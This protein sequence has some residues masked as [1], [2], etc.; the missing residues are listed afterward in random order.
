MSKIMR[1][2]THKYFF[3]I[4]LMM[5]SC[6]D[7]L[8]QS[9]TNSKN[10]VVTKSYTAKMEAVA[11]NYNETDS[12]KV[13][14]G[15]MYMDGMGRPVQDIAIQASPTGKDIVGIHQYDNMSREATQ[16]LPFTYTTGTNNN[17]AFV[18]NA[19][20]TTP[21]GSFQIATG[22]LSNFYNSGVSGVVIDNKPFSTSTFEA[23]PTSRTTLSDIVGQNFNAKVVTPN[24]RFNTATGDKIY[25]IT[26]TGSPLSNST[27]GI[28]DL[29][30][31]TV[32]V[33]YPDNR[34]YVSTIQDADG[35]IGTQFTDMEGKLICKRINM[36]N[37]DKPIDT[38]YVYDDL[39]QL[40][41][42]VTPA[43]IASI[44][45]ATTFPKTFTVLFGA[46]TKIYYFFDYDELGRV[47]VKETPKAG[48][49][50][51]YIVYDQWDRIRCTQDGNQ[52]VNKKWSFISYDK[53]NRPL[54]SGESVFDPAGATTNI[55]RYNSLV[56]KINALTIR[57][58][59]DRSTEIVSQSNSSF[60]ELPT[61]T[62]TLPTEFTLP[63]AGQTGTVNEIMITKLLSV[64]QFDSY[65][66]FSKPG[67]N[68]TNNPNEYPELTGKYDGNVK[69]KLVGSFKKVLSTTSWIRSV[70]FFDFDG[71]AI[72]AS[73]D[74]FGIPNSP[75]GSVT[76]GN[77]FTNTLGAY[78]VSKTDFSW[79]GKAL[80]T[81]TEHRGVTSAGI[82]KTSK[83]FT[84]DHENRLLKTTF[85]ASEDLTLDNGKVITLANL[86][87]NELGQLKRQT[88]GDNPNAP[89]GKQKFAQQFAY[90]YYVNGAVKEM[91]GQQFTE[92]TFYEKRKTDAVGVNT[93]L[94]S[95]LVSESFWQSG[96][97]PEQGQ[98]YNY[99]L[100]NR[101]TSTAGVNFPYSE[102]GITYDNNG[103]IQTLNR[104]WNSAV[105]D[106]LTYNYS[107]STTGA[108]VFLQSINDLAPTLTRPQGVKTRTDIPGQTFEYDYD[109]NGNLTKDGKKG[110]TTA[111][112]Y[113]ILDMVEQISVNGKTV[114]YQYASD[115]EKLVTDMGTEKTVY[116]GAFEYDGS[117]IVVRVGTGAGQLL[118]EVVN[119]TAVYNYQF[120]L[121]DRLGNTRVVVNET[122]D[123]L[124]RS[125]YLAYGMQIQYGN[126]TKNKYLY[127]GK[128]LQTEMGWLDFGARMYDPTIG[129][130]HAPDPVAQ[131]ASPYSYVGGDP[132]NM[133]D[134]DGRDAWDLLRSIIGNGLNAANFIQ[135]FSGGTPFVSPRDFR[136][137]GGGNGGGNGGGGG[138]SAALAG[139][140][141]AFSVASSA[142][143]WFGNSQSYQAA[144][145]EGL[146]NERTQSPMGAGGI[147][148]QR[149]AE[150]FVDVIAS[151]A[152]KNFIKL[153]TF[154]NGESSE[155]KIS[156]LK[157]VLIKRKSIRVIDTNQDDAKAFNLSV[158]YGEVL[159]VD[160]SN[161]SE[162]LNYESFIV[163]TIMNNFVNGTGP[164]NYYFSENSKMSSLFKASD[165]VGKAISQY[166]SGE[167]SG[168]SKKFDF[169][170]EIIY[171]YFRNGTLF[172]I[173]GLVGSASISIR[174][175]NDGI[176]IQIFNVTSLTS[177][178]LPKDLLFL[179]R[180]NVPRS[181][182][183]M[184]SGTNNYS[185]ISQTF[186]LF[187]S[188]K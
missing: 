36:G 62:N 60:F 144:G 77:P 76:L 96:G 175:A 10:Y 43:A 88:I 110:I 75:I 34:L 174:K 140:N 83:T 168:R 79:D 113:N 118:R 97:K 126:S 20:G 71:N 179:P 1:L 148:M 147:E 51:E 52:R 8:A 32:N 188:N 98:K 9:P 152:N 95:G 33:P 125:D 130:W 146:K 6:L 169:K 13:D 137:F 82:K 117:G 135:S 3:F 80:R 99:D 167:W 50:I 150:S 67:L 48:D 132:I 129:R 184:K 145:G 178:Y 157:G 115:G 28:Q 64:N 56:V 177:G 108:K 37:I 78:E 139:L 142:K 74:L 35:R 5:I 53:L 93:G 24:V 160:E 162:F 183:R 161:S 156:E 38:Y 18:N 109:A 40:R 90:S 180:R 70:S 7:L 81:T 29:T 172:S 72:F 55:A 127:E 164:E 176:K 158:N 187:I 17:G 68:Y 19:G 69:G 26:Y 84:Y 149:R 94:F 141:T 107:A 106:S 2:F 171:D 116:A 31:F 49:A 136:G 111:M 134:P 123:T 128:E 131:F 121:Q 186:N 15:I 114:K 54:I 21:S 100:A 119:T 65:Q 63:I 133:I 170:K 159:V 73:S 11:P 47:I 58:E 41:C 92:R 87:Y 165:I 59:T 42:I 173:T 25:Q 14:I 138:S 23:S 85:R 22:E 122:G 166:K 124:Q 91:L 155:L 102:R 86:E 104:V 154:S 61:L 105:I 120:Y 66:N 153:N 4:A 143:Y 181:Y 16:F 151:E 39:N 103:N 12:R 163:A 27:T 57:Y 46:S 89:V 44:P 101:L 30:K 112:T 185:N 182:T 45:T